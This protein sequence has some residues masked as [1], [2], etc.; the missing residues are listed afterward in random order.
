[1]A[2]FVL[3]EVQTL[4]PG[5]VAFCHHD[6]LIPGAMPAVDIEPAAA[7]ITRQ[8]PGTGYFEFE[9]ATPLPLLS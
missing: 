8:A 6:V 5:R 9:Y 3:E 2:Q 7:A 1:M 4:Q